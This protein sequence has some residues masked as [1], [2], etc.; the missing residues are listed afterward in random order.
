MYQVLHL[1]DLH[2]NQNEITEFSVLFSTS[3][4]FCFLEVHFLNRETLTLYFG[5]IN[6]QY[7]ENHI[8]IV[9][10]SCTVDIL[11]K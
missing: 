5:Y 3:Y 4:S 1:A 9:I 7:I 2:Y 11:G 6:L 8:E 10:G